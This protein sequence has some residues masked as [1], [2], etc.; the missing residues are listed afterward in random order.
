VSPCNPDAP[1]SIGSCTSIDN[2]RM[3]HP[4]PRRECSVTK[5]LLRQALVGNGLVHSYNPTID[6]HPGGDRT[7]IAT[8]IAT[9]CLDF[10]AGAQA[11]AAS[12]QAK[13]AGRQVRGADR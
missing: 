8:L 4:K 12:I 7:A 9:I 13:A 6:V 1:A 5:Y 3:G 11:F 10:A 2:S